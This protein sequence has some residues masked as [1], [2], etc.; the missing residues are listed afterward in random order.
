MSTMKEKPAI[1]QQSSENNSV[2]SSE[3]DMAN[4]VFVSG[5]DDNP[6]GDGV[7]A[8]DRSPEQP[9]LDRHLPLLSQDGMMLG[10]AGEEY[11]GT[12][13]L[14]IDP[15]YTESDGNVTTKRRIRS[16]SSRHRGEIVT[17]LGPEEVRWFYKEDKRTW[18]PFVGHDSL[19]IETVYR[20]FCEQNP[21]KVK[22]L[23]DPSEAEGKEAASS[24]E[25]QPES[26]AVDGGSVRVE[27]VVQQRGGQQHSV[28]EEMRDLDD[29][30]VEAVC[31]R[32]GLYEVDIRE[33]ECYPVYWNQ[34]D[35][36][37]V[38]RG[39]WFIDGT[40]LP[41]EED[42]SD[43]IEM[44]HLARFRGQQMRD[45]YEMEVVT[46]TV[47]SK[48]AIHSLK[49]SR[50][51]VDWHSVDEVYLYSDATT[52]KIARTVTQ[53]LGFSKA[54]SSGTRLHRG[55]VEEAAPEDTPPETTHIVFVVHGIGQKMDQGRIIR[56]T[57]MM[58]DAARKMEEKHFSDRTTEHVEFLPVE[59]RSKLALDGDTV[60]SIT[61]DKVRGLRDMLNSSAMDI[62]YYTSPLYRD[63]ITK[64]L[65]LELNRLYSLFCS[66]NPDFEK[67]GKVSIVSHSLGCVITFDI[68]TG[69]DPVRFHHQE[70]PDLEE[71]KVRWASDEEHHLQEQL[72]LTRLRLR[73][74][75]DQFHGLQTSSCAVPA[76]KF[77]VEN[78]FC[79]GSPLAVFLALRGTRP[80]NNNVQDHI[81][82][83]TIC[84][85]L[86]N[87]F[88]PT[89][90][91]AYRLEPL[92]LKHYSNI[93]PVQIHWYN[94]SNPTPYDHIRPTLL[95]PP[96]ET[97][98]VS[99]SESIPSPCTS[100][101]QARR[102]YGESIT[103]LGKASIMGAASLG[104]GIGGILFSRFS[105]S[106]GQVGG[107]EEEPI[108]SEGGASEVE[109]VSS[110]EE[111]APVA[112]TEVKD[113][114]IEE[115][116]TE[117]EPAMSQSTSSV[118]DS[119]SLELERRI[120]FELREG[121]VESRYWS[122]VTSHTAYWCSYDVALFLLTFMY[123]PQESLEP[124]ED[125]SETS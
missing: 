24:G 14:D 9:G 112:E 15:E 62:M 120:D 87:I 17:E 66:R 38:M 97:A 50:S 89:D 47:D 43:L 110:G 101:P 41:L 94:T 75:E 95:N 23:V 68:M 64:G 71:T 22:R 124:A 61:P 84:K 104:K 52:S 96:K 100:P 26:G 48:D 4:D 16:N 77:K 125:N 79:M 57:S 54:S 92:I 67:N 44:E 123:R 69:W 72:R 80:G 74:L 13:Y 115:D 114:E 19:K 76:L 5:Y 58:R 78:F 55:Y 93:V 29:I 98:S 32:G 90:P 53:K 6:M 121:L 108:D 37:P 56:N 35:R 3:W 46:T 59:W 27:S 103:S 102:H 2:S 91:V 119:T 1:R 81:L 51:H 118:M 18:K 42:E 45:T 109:N 83:T 113:K 36:I 106:S 30:S 107:V 105:R 25:I 34:Q 31:V 65:T 39:Q 63:E 49:L 8:A 85:R 20:R 86:F 82:P 40:W 117:V 28:S 73:D 88:H 60:D 122:A 116:R 99:D 11:S 10:L 12:S 70:A 33:K 21:D 7:A 111:G